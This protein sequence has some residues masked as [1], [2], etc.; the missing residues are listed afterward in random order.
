MSSIFG[1]DSVEKAKKLLLSEWEKFAA[2]EY[3]NNPAIK[4]ITLVGSRAE[5]TERPDSDADFKILIDKPPSYIH[6]NPKTGEETEITENR[7][8][9]TVDFTNY[10][11]DTEVDGVVIDPFIIFRPEES[12]YWS[13]TG[14]IVASTNDERRKDLLRRSQQLVSEI[15]EERR[16]G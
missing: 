11:R 12:D 16:R 10:I 6:K 14:V 2:T 13:P 7:D 4:S 15:Q 1:R 3:I 5:G 9:V 8:M